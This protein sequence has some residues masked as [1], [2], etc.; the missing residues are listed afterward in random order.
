M[1]VWLTRICNNKKSFLF[2]LKIS[3]LYVF[4]V[5]LYLSE[6]NYFLNE[7]TCLVQCTIKEM[8]KYWCKKKT[9]FKQKLKNLN[10]DVLLFSPI[11][12]HFWAYAKKKSVEFSFFFLVMQKKDIFLNVHT[13]EN[14]FVFSVQKLLSEC[15]FNS[16]IETAQVSYI[17]LLISFLSWLNCEHLIKTVCMFL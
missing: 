14:C 7:S 6:I 15:Y 9:N 2:E 1:N 13:L 16:P 17:Q 4:N 12:V 5:H 8:V 3:S 11:K 10:N